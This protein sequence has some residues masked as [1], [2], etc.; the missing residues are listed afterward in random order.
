MSHHT[1]VF[2]YTYAVF[3]LGF[4]IGYWFC[5]DMRGRK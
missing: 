5:K 3:F 4:A 1:M 2:I